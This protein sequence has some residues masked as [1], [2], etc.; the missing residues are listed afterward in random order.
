MPAPKFLS[1]KEQHALVIQYDGL[2]LG[3]AKRYTK[4]PSLDPDTLQ[5]ARLGLVE[6]ARHF[7]PHRNVKFSTYAVYWVKALIFRHITIARGG[8][9][10]I[11]TTN[12][13]RQVMFGL[14]RAIQDVGDDN[15]AIAMHLHVG[16]EMVEVVRARLEARDVALDSPTSFFE[17][18]DEHRGP[19]ERFLEREERHNVARWINE[20][21]AKMTRRERHIFRGRWL[22]EQPKTLKELGEELG[23]LSR[24][25]VRQIE[26]RM[27][28]RLRAQADPTAEA[29]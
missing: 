20:N 6:A 1:Q 7:E 5:V 22:S 15:E 12:T 3:M 18:V 28:D 23:G 26:A 25:R 4:G 27:L 24:E 16:T 13:V 11:G 8:P 10:S 21:L 14:S 17:L 19:E 2:A 9:V 29:A